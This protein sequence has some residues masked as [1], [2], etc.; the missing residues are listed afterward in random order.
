MPI[1][2]KHNDAP[3]LFQTDV[4]VKGKVEAITAASSGHRLYYDHPNG[5]LY[6]G[7]SIDWLASLAT[8]SVNLI[9]A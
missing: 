3:F 5:K 7:D 1:K 6:Q 9:F 2:R 8:S 4:I